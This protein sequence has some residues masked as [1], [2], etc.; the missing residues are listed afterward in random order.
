MKK[1]E[2]WAGMATMLLLISMIM[3]VSAMTG[4]VNQELIY[5]NI[6]ITLNGKQLNLI[7]A[8]GNSVEPFMFNGTNYLPVRAI[9]EALGL[10]VGWD[11][12]TST[13]ILT[14]KSDNQD[15][16]TPTIPNTSYSRIN[17]A[18]IGTKQQ[19]T[20]K[21]YWG[22]Y[23]ATVEIID[24]FRGDIAWAKIRESNKYNSAPTASR[25]YILAAIRITIDSV[26]TDRAISISKYDFT[27]FDS[28]NAEYE[29]VSTV[30]PK[31]NLSGDIYAGGTLEGWVSF[32]VD[33]DD[34]T[35]KVV[36]GADSNGSGGIWFSL[37]H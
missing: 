14:S 24:A 17:P 27:A 5:N 4:T 9:S 3:T 29:L 30:N 18:P 15:Q 19:V 28:Q 16:T 6:G 1:K 11:A 13:I 25:E 22:S 33:T 31:P 35:P 20:V 32:V 8:N 23:T 34:E 7:D 26:S 10:D 21:Q 37:V 12:A 2:F 36:Y